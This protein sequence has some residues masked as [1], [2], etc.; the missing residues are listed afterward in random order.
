MLNIA[1]RE[2]RSLF[3]SPLVW[4]L[5]AAIAGLMGWL[6]LL[7]LDDFLQI[8][9]KLVALEN[10]PGLTDLVAGPHLETAAVLALLVLPL[11][12]MRLL[13][14]EFRSGTD[15]LLFSAPISPLRIILGKYLA[16]LAVQGIILL[17]A[18]LIILSLTLGT[19]LDWGQIAAGLLGLGLT[20][21]AFSAAALCVSGLTAQP[22]AAAAGTFGLLMFLWLLDL[23]ANGAGV[24]LLAE[25]SPATHLRPLLRGLA[26]SADLAYFGLFIGAFLLLTL[27]RFEQRRHP[28]AL[29]ARSRWRKRLQDALLLLLLCAVLGLAGW[30]S[31]QYRIVWDC[32][33]SARNSLSPVSQNVV[34]RLKAPLHITAFASTKPQLRHAIQGFIARYQRYSPLVELEFVNPDTSPQLVRQLGI[35]INGELHLEHQG[36]T[37]NLQRIDEETLTNAI[38]QLIPQDNAWIAS[39]VGHGERKI[40]GKANQDWGDFGAELRRKGYRTQPLELTKVTE[41][42]R[43]TRL[44]ILNS[45]K[46]PLLTAETNQLIAYL[47][48]GGNLLWLQEPDDP[49]GFDTLA[50]HLG[51]HRHPGTVV[52]AN[53]SSLGLSDPGFAL[54]PDYPD[55]PATAGFQ[56][57]TVFPQAAALY[58]DLDSGWQV[59]PLLRTQE[60][61]WTETDPI[62]GLIRQD[63]EA[64]EQ[65][66]PLDIGLA[67]TRGADPDRQRALVIGD[68]D[69]LANTY[70]GNGG[71]LDLGLNLIRW[72]TGDHELLQIPARTAPDLQLNLSPRD[73]VLI[74]VGLLMVL[75][76]GLLFGGL[77]LWWRRRMA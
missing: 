8:Q 49:A 72:L 6:F 26:D 69:F 77:F 32:S 22:G 31:N 59:R 18:L 50:D 63:P 66:G 5:L 30:L 52:D 55:H 3:Y 61:S 19:D 58:S 60:Q 74:S 53:A 46:I 65:A 24:N 1:A 62:K 33:A 64:G 42:P 25:L 34:Q 35:T 21:A 51:V 12:G 17:L 73:S 45:P 36:R 14:E 70:I 15:A 7:R 39:I 16:L 28:P 41:V 9:S 67:L 2:L 23:S 56:F 48:R 44:V 20:L 11:L 37:K 27:W 75:P 38:Q 13:A 76:L 4:V 40:D 29:D 57:L 71:N 47:E 43:N 10:P 68:G 54:V